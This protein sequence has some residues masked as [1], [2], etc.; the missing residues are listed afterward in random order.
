MGI[1]AKAVVA[2][3]FNADV[4]VLSFRYKD[5]RVI[6]NRREIMV[7]DIAT[8]ADAVEVMNSLKDIVNNADEITKK[9]RTY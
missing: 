7:K 9:V 3:A 4:P 6:V 5:W 8:E 1:I 2:P